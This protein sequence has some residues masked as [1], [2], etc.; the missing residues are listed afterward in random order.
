MPEM[1]N[2]LCVPNAKHGPHNEG[3][4]VHSLIGSFVL[5][6]HISH[7]PSLYISVLLFTGMEDRDSLPSSLHALDNFVNFVFLP[8]FYGRKISS[9]LIV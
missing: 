8:R 5:S 1:H 7:S 2:A 6:C 4:F 3:D 9:C